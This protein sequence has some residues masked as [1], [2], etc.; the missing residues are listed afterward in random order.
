MKSVRDNIHSGDEDFTDVSGSPHMEKIGPTI[1]D[2][3]DDLAKSEA[4]IDRLYVSIIALLT[5]IK[6]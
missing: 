6:S 1:F 3:L 5:G 4:A 2:M